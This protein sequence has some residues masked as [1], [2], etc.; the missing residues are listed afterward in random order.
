MHRLVDRVDNVERKSSW[1][2]QQNNTVKNPN[3][4]RNQNPNAGRMSPDCEIRPPFQENYTEAST[5][6]DPLEDSHINLMGLKSDQQVFLSEEDQD[7]DDFHQMQSQTQESLNSKQA[8]DPVVYELNKQYKLRTR[9]VEVPMTIKPKEKQQPNKLK[10]KVVITEHA[11]KAVPNTQ[12]I[13]I[14]DITEKQNSDIQPLPPFSSKENVHTVPKS[15]P[16]T[17]KTQKI[18][19]P[20]AGSQEQNTEISIEKDKSS[21]LNTKTLLDKPFNLETEIGKLKVSIPL[22]ELAKHDVYRQQIQKSLQIP[23]PEMLMCP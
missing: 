12:Q 23:E 17:E 5:S 8:Y 22:S 20:N 15:L 13:T 3:F 18:T 14:D 1:D 4:R 16:I 19:L 6:N 9:T 10:G 7:S 11:E 21:I 2:G